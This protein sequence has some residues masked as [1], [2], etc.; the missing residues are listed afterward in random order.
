MTN[1]DPTLAHGPPAP[2]SPTDTTR[3]HTLGA[4]P[5]IGPGHP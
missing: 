2:V 1:M 5:K 4:C 3:A